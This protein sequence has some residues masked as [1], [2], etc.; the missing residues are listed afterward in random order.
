MDETRLE[1]CSKCLDD[2]EDRLRYIEKNNK[3]DT[4]LDALET[5]VWAKFESNEKIYTSRLN[6]LEKFVSDN[7]AVIAIKKEDKHDTL[8]VISLVIACVSLVLVALKLL[9]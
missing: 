5:K 6:L 3:F 8:A 7:V 9:L 2:H 4:K 1:Y